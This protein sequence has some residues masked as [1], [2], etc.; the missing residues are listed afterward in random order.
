MEGYDGKQTCF[1][2]GTPFETAGSHFP[3]KVMSFTTVEV[4]VRID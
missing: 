4:S 2:D 3:R 1:Q